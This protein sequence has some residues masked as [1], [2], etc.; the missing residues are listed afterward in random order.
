MQ[1]LGLTEFSREGITV[2][3]TQKISVRKLVT[4]IGL[5]TKQGEEA[6]AILRM[7][8]QLA[9][10]TKS[11][12]G[13]APCPETPSIALI[14]HLRT[15]SGNE[16]FVAVYE[17]RNKLLNNY[18]TWNITREQVLQRLPRWNILQQLLVHAGSLPVATEIQPQV[19]A[20]LSERRLLENPDPVP[21]LINTLSTALRGALS[22]EYQRLSIER[23]QGVS[24]LEGTEEWQRLSTTDREQTL[25]RYNLLPVSLPRIGTDEE[26]LTALDKTPLASWEERLALPRVR[27]SQIRE[28]AIKLSLPKAVQI[29]P[30]QATLNSVEEVD[31][32]LV[33]LREQIL[34]HIEAGNPVVI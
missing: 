4:E 10:T 11:A 8:E 31:T 24:T 19:E 23:D 33:R 22:S 29:R 14:D 26:L 1:Q 21:P 6:E 18:K 27:V 2:T 30:P 32:Y 15:L 3:V 17:Q 25:A 7:L 34:P 13:P 16:Q 9:D 28:E 12:G 5:P 20:I